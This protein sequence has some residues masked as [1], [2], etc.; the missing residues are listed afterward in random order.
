MTIM[1]RA[2]E[3][4]VYNELFGSPVLRRKC[5]PKK[6][7]QSILCPEIGMFHCHLI[8]LKTPLLSMVYNGID[9][10]H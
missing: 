3:A 2:A 4:G 10:F 7:V 6:I 9:C 1:K 5:N 8:V